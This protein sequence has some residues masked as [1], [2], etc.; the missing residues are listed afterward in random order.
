MTEQELRDKIADLLFTKAL[1]DQKGEFTSSLEYAA[2]ILAL[3]DAYY[4]ET[5]YVKLGKEQ[6][7]QDGTEM[8]NHWKQAGG[9]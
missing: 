4:K 2:Q 6:E 3:T 1:K 7:K 5:G 8:L 9:K